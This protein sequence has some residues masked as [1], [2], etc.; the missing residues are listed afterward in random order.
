MFTS[1]AEFR[2]S[3]RADNADLRLTDKGMAWGCVGSAR[4]AAFTRYRTTLTAALDRARQEGLPAAATERLGIVPAADGRWR[5]VLELAG[6]AVVAWPHCATAFPWLGS[7]PDADCGAA[8]DGCPLR[9]IFA[10]P[11]SRSPAE[12]P[13]GQRRPCDRSYSTKSAACRPK[14]VRSSIAADRSRSAR[15]HGSRA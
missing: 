15:R 14:S 10:P 2:L 9:R 1:R 8:T 6:N 13:R 7:L 5:S 3:L 12:P 4:A 11:A